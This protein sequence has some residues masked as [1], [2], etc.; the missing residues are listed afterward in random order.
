MERFSLILCRINHYCDIATS[1][2][3]TDVVVCVNTLYSY[4]DSCNLIFVNLTRN[5]PPSAT[6]TEG[7]RGFLI[8]DVTYHEF[9]YNAVIWRQIRWLG[10]SNGCLSMVCSCCGVIGPHV[11][12]HTWHW[13]LAYCIKWLV[14]SCKVCKRWYDCL[15]DSLCCPLVPTPNVLSWCWNRTGTEWTELCNV[16]KLC[17]W[18]TET[19]LQ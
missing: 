7:W 3:S 11:S 4:L 1:E 18:L 2:G 5:N 16:A 13:A 10:N 15:Y 6:T 8:R 14:F 17:V 12:V 19:G 9:P